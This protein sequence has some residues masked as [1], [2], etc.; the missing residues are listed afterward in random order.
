MK[1]KAITV[2]TKNVLSLYAQHLHIHHCS[3]SIRTVNKRF[4]LSLRYDL[5]ADAQSS[6]EQRAPAEMEMIR[7][8]LQK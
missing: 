8:H 5:T 7:E 3:K 1:V 4:L 2:R 6:L